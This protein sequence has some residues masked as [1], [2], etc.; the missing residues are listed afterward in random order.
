MDFRLPGLDGAEATAAVLAAC[1]ESAVVCLTAEATEAEDE[2]VRKSGAAAL[3]R[4]GGPI[5]DLVAAIRS[6]GARRT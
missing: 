4:K 3:V 2:A 6:A 1:P 5:G